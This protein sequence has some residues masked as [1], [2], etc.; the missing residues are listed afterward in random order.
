MS[1]NKAVYLIAFYT[2]LCARS[3]WAN[4]SSNL[5]VKQIGEEAAASLYLPQREVV[6]YRQSLQRDPF[7]VLTKSTTTSVQCPSP[8]KTYSHDEK[9]VLSGYELDQLQLKGVIGSQSVVTAIITT[10]ENELIRL[11][12]GQSV[13]NNQGIVVEVSA[14]YLVIEEWILDAYGCKQPQRTTLHLSS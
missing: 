10:P 5:M 7:Q 6:D 9:A 8:S 14:S 11:Q 4:S 12:S 1:K 13:G 3:G 2:L